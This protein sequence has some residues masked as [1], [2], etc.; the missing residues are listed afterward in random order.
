[1]GLG[2]APGHIPHIIP[3]GTD[4][5]CSV[6]VALDGPRCS[7]PLP[8][9]TIWDWSL[10]FRQ[11]VGNKPCKHSKKP[12]TLRSFLMSFGQTVDPRSST[13]TI[14]ES[15]WYSI[16]ET[17]LFAITQYRIVYIH[18]QVKKVSASVKMQLYMK[19]VTRSVLYSFNV[20]MMFLSVGNVFGTAL[21]I[22]SNWTSY[23]QSI[24]LLILLTDSDR[25]QETIA[26]LTGT[27][28]WNRGTRLTS[29]STDESPKDISTA[30]S[31]VAEVIVFGD[32][33]LNSGSTAA[34]TTQNSVR[35][36]PYIG[37]H[38]QSQH[39]TSMSSLPRNLSNRQNDGIQPLERRETQDIPL[40]NLRNTQAVGSQNTESILSPTSTTRSFNE[41][42]GHPTLYGRPRNGLYTGVQSDPP[43]F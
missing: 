36:S 21:G 1:M 41:Q 35:A 33:D 27:T 4:H 5:T 40:A 17:I 6:Q 24:T 20:T 3:S 9:S 15:F 22:G 2:L 43:R 13:V 14:V 37:T 29:P 7:L 39:A 12:D 16:I 8:S 31:V 18:S 10:L 23:G 25:F 30:N 38:T 19:A 42:P 11:Q 32:S 34:I 28:D 26:V